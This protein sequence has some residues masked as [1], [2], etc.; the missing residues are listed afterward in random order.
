VVA[1]LGS[2]RTLPDPASFHLLPL[3]LAG[4]LA[5]LIVGTWRGHLDRQA[6]RRVRD[7]H[8]DLAGAR[9]P[10]GWVYAL[11]LASI[12]SVLGWGAGRGE[13][14]I[15][16]ATLLGVTLG[17]LIVA[18]LAYLLGSVTVSVFSR[19]KRTE[20]KH[21]PRAYFTDH[22]ISS[23]ADDQLE[24]GPIVDLLVR[25][26][27]ELRDASPGF[28]S[29]EG[30]WGTGKSTVV[31]LARLKL[32]EH[33]HVSAEFSG[34]HFA[35]TDRLVDALATT[36]ERALNARFASLDPGQAFAAFYRTF[37]PVAESGLPFGLPAITEDHATTRDRL[38]TL[39]A[40]VK[41][42]IVV[43]LEDLDRM[44]GEDLL[45]LLGAVQL[46]GGIEGFVFVLVLDRTHCAT[47]LE[48][49]V[50]DPAEYL[51]KS[52]H[53]AIPLP[54]PPDYVLF[55]QFV[56][57]LDEVEKVRCISVTAPQGSTLLAEDWTT[58]APTLRHLKQL[59]NAYSTTMALLADEIDPFDALLAAAVDQA[60]PALLP[61]IE[62]HP[63]PWLTGMGSSRSTFAYAMRRDR[64]D[65][66]AARKTLLDDLELGDRLRIVQPFIDQLFPPHRPAAV[67]EEGQHL[68]SAEYFARYRE[69][70]LRRASVP[71]RWIVELVHEIDAAGPT[72]AS[73]VVAERFLASRN[74]IALFN[75]LVVRP[76]LFAAEVRLPVIAACAEI[77]D[78]LTDTRASFEPTEVDRARA[79]VFA[80]IEQGKG[81]EDW[82]RAAIDIAIR[83]SSSMEFAR[84]LVAFSAPDR[85]QIVT[86]FSALGLDR[87]MVVLAETVKC[88]LDAGYDPFESEPTTAPW[89]LE[90]LGDPEAAATWVV[91]HARLHE[92]LEGERPYGRGGTRLNVIDW[93]RLRSGFDLEI[94]RASLPEEGMADLEELLRVGPSEITDNNPRVQG[95]LDEAATLEAPNEGDL[96]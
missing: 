3:L 62:K 64:E 81:D 11:L 72:Q 76:H 52:I 65:R 8:R 9:S 78:R 86:D 79:L 48:G 35:T 32:Q 91:A 60:A 95:S 17:T 47:Q 74:R 23:A 1:G 40:P 19:P 5:I 44:R 61:A 15:V 34:F 53:V 18:I 4:I 70:A 41:K 29:L 63:A 88:R 12:G 6:V 24:R 90:A 46:L 57:M 58:L 33:G 75:K 93:E 22:P 59:A 50:P 25:A 69:G 77:S 36:I 83:S 37:R 54:P 13:P 56:S 92:L 16:V 84:V 7:T 67:D 73:T 30:D 42:P 38:K 80:L 21:E 96:A 85:N 27:T 26:I 51:R 28:V 39:L 10:V 66:Q 82:Q 20:D 87:L 55:E 71:D 49:L 68:A 45:K 14:P 43:F 89:I 2:P 31:A 94:L